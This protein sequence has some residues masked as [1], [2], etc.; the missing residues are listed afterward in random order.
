M[1][2]SSAYLHLAIV[3]LVWGSTFLAIRVAV[4]EGSGFPPFTMAASRV[5]LA[6]VLLILWAAASRRR[7]R[8]TRREWITLAGSGLLLWTGGNGLVVWAEQRA[9]SGLAALVIAAVPLW[10]ALIEAVLD[11]RRP[12][13]LLVGALLIGLMGVGL[14]SAPAFASSIG[15]DLPSIA[16]LLLAS[17]S[18]AF[19]VVLQN[20]RPVELSLRVSSAY[21]HM[22]GGLGFLLL[23][24]LTNEPSPNPAPDAW[25]A[26]GYL[27]LFG[28]VLGF[29]SYVQT[30][31]SLPL[32]VATTNAYV[33]PVIA[34][35]L[36]AVILNEPVTAWTTSGAALILIGVAG[37]FRDRRLQDRRARQRGEAA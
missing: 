24:A 25:V 36:G 37:V 26:W 14:L 2:R 3:Y 28:S 20:R 6:S 31:R 18:W 32:S 19:G 10:V 13:T 27:V 16:A 23:V 34:V 7:I 22:A 12:S 8:P 1:N 29:T 4:R 11:R 30:L 21:Q 5:L 33:N 17:V 35:V 15:A 9:D